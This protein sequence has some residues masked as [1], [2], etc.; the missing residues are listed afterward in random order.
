MSWADVASGARVE[1]EVALNTRNRALE[2]ELAQMKQMMLEHHQRIVALE[3][4]NSRLR[5]EN[6]SLKN[7]QGVTLDSIEE[8]EADMEE[9]ANVPAKRKA[10]DDNKTIAVK[11]TKSVKPLEKRQDELESKIDILESK[12]DIIST[13]FTDLGTQI[14]QQVTQAIMTQI[15]Q[16]FNT[17]NT[18]FA[19]IESRMKTWGPQTSGGGPIK[20][21]SKPYNKP[22]TPTVEGTGKL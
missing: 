11:K 17:I 16:Q 12:L 21:T 1:A 7:G 13:Q 14:T 20:T 2:K 3:E 10:T 19:D 15:Q 5:K 4:E 6:I 9:E 8:K 22:S 18:K